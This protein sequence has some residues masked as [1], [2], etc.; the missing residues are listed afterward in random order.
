MIPIINKPTRV[1]K[2]TTTAIDYILCNSYT[3]TIFK[4]AIRKC[5][6]SDHFPICLIKPSLKFSSNNKII[7]T[8]KRSF[9]EQSIFNF[10]N[11]L[12]QIDWQEIE[13]LQNPYSL[14]QFLTL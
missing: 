8:C 11:K 12:F 5:D 9:N 14:E 4:T 1:T 3:E 10:K 6:I 7:N 2:K 13:T